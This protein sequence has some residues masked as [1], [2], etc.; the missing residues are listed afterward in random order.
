MCHYHLKVD[1]SPFCASFLL[2]TKGV[3]IV[4]ILH[5]LYFFL[6]QNSGFHLFMIKANQS[7][8]K[9]S[10]SKSYFTNIEVQNVNKAFVYIKNCNSSL[11]ISYY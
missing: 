11:N 4:Q 7:S 9:Y 8:F 10:V 5:L 2:I 6:N 1:Y 3:N